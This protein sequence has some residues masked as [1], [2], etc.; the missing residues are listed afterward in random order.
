MKE[1]RFVGSHPDELDGGRPIEPGEFVGPIEINDDP[2]SEGY[3]PKNLH[4]LEDGNLIEVPEGTAAK[5]QKQAEAEAPPVPDDDGQL[6]GE[7]LD[8]RAAELDIK[9][10]SSMSADQLRE[11]V[12][13]AEAQA[14]ANGENDDINPEG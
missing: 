12:T 1:Y 14:T 9:G 11:A 2:D 13:E 6:R 7:S 8:R 10:R 3:T 5:V 4:L